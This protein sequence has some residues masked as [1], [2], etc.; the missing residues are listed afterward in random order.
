MQVAIEHALTILAWH[1]N[2]Q[3]D[4]VPPEHI[5]EDSDALDEWWELVRER[6]LAKFGGGG[7]T[8]PDEEDMTDNELSRQF[9]ME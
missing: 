4:D 3:K 7:D 9:K 5:W 2:N 8:V 1:E 6:Q